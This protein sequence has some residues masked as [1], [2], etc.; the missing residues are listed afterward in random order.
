M[1]QVKK[2]SKNMS[3]ILDDKGNFDLI[4]NQK[5]FSLSV[6]G[7]KVWVKISPKTAKKLVKELSK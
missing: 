1:A 4:F 2:L 5:S 3:L 6:D 7:S